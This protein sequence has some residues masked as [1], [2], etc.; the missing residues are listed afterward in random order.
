MSKDKKIEFIGQRLL[1]TPEAM[2]YLGVKSRITFKKKYAAKYGLIDK[3][4]D[5]WPRYDIR[6]LEEILEKKTQVPSSSEKTHPEIKKADKP[7]PE[8]KK[9]FEAR[10]EGIQ[11]TLDI[12][13]PF[14]LSEHKKVLIKAL[15]K[16]EENNAQVKLIN[17]NGKN[18][19]S[20]SEIG[21]ILEAL[22]YGL[23]EGFFN[24]TLRDD[25]REIIALLEEK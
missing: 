17:L 25:V 15:G 19:L 5:N 23:G 6:D 18:F 8:I 3:S 24:M 21:S 12:P 2:L 11:L 20:D 22:S 16:L 7:N 10:S 1:T 14:N 9:H 13:K 4:E